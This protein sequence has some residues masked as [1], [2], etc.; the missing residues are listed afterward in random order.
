VRK[1]KPA[2][3]SPAPTHGKTSG[4]RGRGIKSF[5]SGDK[6]STLELALAKPV[7][8]SKKF[9]AKSFGLGVAKKATAATVRI[10]SKKMYTATAGGSDE[11]RAPTR[12][13]DLFG[14]A[15]SASDDETTIWEPPRKRSSKF[16]LSKGAPKPFVM[17]GNFE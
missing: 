2:T 10:T 4:K 6:T 16:P 15:S 7:K 13:L 12:A 14:S 17:K 8:H 11:T 5:D 1:H 3:A 9:V